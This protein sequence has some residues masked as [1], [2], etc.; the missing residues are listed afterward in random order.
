M[1]YNLWQTFP[2]EVNIEETS[3]MRPTR[4]AMKNFRYGYYDWRE[5]KA[6]HVSGKHFDRG[7][8]FY[9]GDMPVENITTFNC[10][11]TSLAEV[12]RLILFGDFRSCNYFKAN[13]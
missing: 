6:L 10:L 7:Y 11:E 8:K 3:I 5:T 9:S 4:I 1:A 2:E 12:A 13:A